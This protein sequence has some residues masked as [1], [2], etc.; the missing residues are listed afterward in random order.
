MLNSLFLYQ[1]LYP[2]ELEL[3]LFSAYSVSTVSYK[4]KNGQFTTLWLTQIY[5]VPQCPLKHS[6]HH[7]IQNRIAHGEI[8]NY[9][10]SYGQHTYIFKILEVVNLGQ[11]LLLPFL[12]FLCPLANF[13]L[14]EYIFFKPIVRNCLSGFIEV[15]SFS[16]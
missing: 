15:S 7:V 8:L 16:Y 10:Y 3:V 6:D 11:R 14:F 13:I 12:I 4:Y 2:K 1:L 9:E 5:R